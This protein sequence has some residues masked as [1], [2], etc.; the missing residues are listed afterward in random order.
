[1]LSSATEV[2]DFSAGAAEVAEVG[3]GQT[4]LAAMKLLR[5]WMRGVVR[6]WS[7]WPPDLIRR[8]H[9]R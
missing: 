3:K 9:G 4:S 2:T 5:A 7:W 1:V 6:A 8:F